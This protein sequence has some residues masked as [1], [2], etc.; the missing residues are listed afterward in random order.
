VSTPTGAATLQHV[1]AAACERVGLDQ[2]GAEPIRLGENAIFR[3]PGRV[4][5]RIARPGQ[6]AA[7][8]KEVRIARWFAEHAV[9]AVRTLDGV[10]QPI[11]VGGRPV[12][13]W[14]ELPPHRHGTVVEI[15][16][17][18]RHLHDLPVPAGL[19]D[20]LDPFVRLAERIDTGTTLPADDRA[21]LHGRLA[22]LREQYRTLPVGLPTTVV[23]GDAWGGNIVTT[24]SGRTV[25]LDL[26]RCSIGPPEWDMVSIAIRRT[27]FTW[28]PEPDYRDFCRRYGRDVTTW[29]GYGLLRDIR[30]LRMALYR[31]QRA[32]EHPEDRSEA[33]LRVACL[34]GRHGPRPWPWGR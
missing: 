4:V 10:E 16:D 12:T 8:S 33:E 21:W 27:S 28:L 15:A 26:E 22:E 25:L 30:E 18:L 9:P 29:S 7:A 20:P 23:H 2:A 19:L 34:R 17:V 11:E 14:E 32:A 6:L 1:L 3:L 5:V 31:V 24:D 13:F